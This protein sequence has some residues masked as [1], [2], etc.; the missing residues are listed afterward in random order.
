MVVKAVLL[1]AILPPPPT[2]TVLITFHI[3]TERQR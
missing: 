3:T 2:R 1:Q